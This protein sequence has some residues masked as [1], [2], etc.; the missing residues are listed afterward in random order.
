MDERQWAFYE[1]ADGSTPVRKDLEKARLAS[2]ETTKLAAL[3]RR[4]QDRQTLPGDVKD[5]GNDLLEVR[6]TGNR[7]IFRLLYAEEAGGLVLLALCFFQKKSQKT[8]PN[9]RDT[10]ERRLKDWRN[11]NPKD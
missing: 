5:L 11:R 2:H 1:G 7:R 6:L 8:P 10:A 4:V 9:E 3:M